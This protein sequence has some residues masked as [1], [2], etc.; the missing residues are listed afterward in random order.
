MGLY[1]RI[2]EL[3]RKKRIAMTKLESELG[4]GRG[5]LGKLKGGKTTSGERIQ[6]IA[7]YFGVSV[8]YLLSEYPDTP[9]EDV[10]TSVQPK[11]Y[12]DPETAEAAQEYFDEYRIL[13]DAARGSRPEDLKMAAD[14]LMRLKGRI[15]EE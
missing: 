11:Y 1:E 7:D 9:R 13:F 8:D 15:R 4:F 10:Q 2:A 14:L 5:S 3:C 12:T 6:K